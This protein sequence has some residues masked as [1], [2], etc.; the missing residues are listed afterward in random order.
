MHSFEVV[1]FRLESN[2]VLLQNNAFE[3]TRV[4][5]RRSILRV[6]VKRWRS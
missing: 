6:Y 5:S 1:G 3:P 2:L 4:F